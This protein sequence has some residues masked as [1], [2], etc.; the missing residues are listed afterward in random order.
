MMIDLMKLQCLPHK[1]ATILLSNT[2][3]V[4]NQ[5]K[6]QEYEYIYNMTSLFYFK[7]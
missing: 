6:K 7:S 2:R 1:L 3:N 5:Q 4:L